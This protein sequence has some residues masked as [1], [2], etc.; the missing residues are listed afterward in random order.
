MPPVKSFRSRNSFRLGL[1]GLALMLVLGGLTLFWDR[2]P[3]L[4]GTTYT[5]EFT[6]AAGL[7][8][9]DEVRVAG[10]KVGEVT[11]VSLDGDH[12]KVTFRVT[13]TWVGDESTVSVRIKTLL[14]A[15]NL[16][17]DPR[18]E[19]EQDPDQ[20]IPRGRTVTPYDVNDAFADLA[21]TTGE[22]DTDQLAASFRTLAQTFDAATPQDVRSALDGLAALSQTISSR[23]TELK[24]LLSGTAQLSGTVAERTDQL[25]RLITDGNVLLTEFDQRRS[26]LDQLLRGTRDLSQQVRGLIEENNAQLQPA[27]EQLDRV[28]DVLQRN[29]NT[30]DRSLSLSG[31]FYRLL[32]DAIGNGNWIDTY[33]CGL[34]VPA[35]GGP[36]MPPKPG[37]GG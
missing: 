8:S 33:L 21:R 30:L 19:R 26:A 28:I 36:C 29:Q 14:G 23:D 2:L 31:P 5:A 9:G 32:G 6:E 27:L 25:A 22:L 12:V 20:P 13:D 24:Q 11:G 15:K 10:A 16:A 35:D 34:I 3:A 7:K 4:G 1:A 18:G 17:L 37:G